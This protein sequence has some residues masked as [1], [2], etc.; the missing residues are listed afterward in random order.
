[1]LPALESRQCS[2]VLALATGAAICLGAVPAGAAIV[3]GTLTQTDF[4]NGETA[5]VF[6]SKVS[7]FWKYYYFSPGVGVLVLDP[8]GPNSALVRANGF[9]GIDFRPAG[10]YLGP[11]VY[12]VQ[13]V[14]VQVQEDVTDEYIS[15]KFQQSGQTHFGWVHVINSDLGLESI[16]LDK[17]GYENAANTSLLTLA[18]SCATRHL[19]LANGS[20]KLCWTNANE[21]GVSRYEVQQ[22]DAAGKWQS[23]STEVP[24]GGQY[25]FSAKSGTYRLLVEKLDGSSEVLSF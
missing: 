14:S 23:V 19:S 12:P 24:N 10:S 25:S 6:D 3:T 9:G 16:Q 11:G 21:Q 1:M 15:I 2:P 22:K 18:P 8:L 13:N 4:A 20:S 17:W 5:K 7:L